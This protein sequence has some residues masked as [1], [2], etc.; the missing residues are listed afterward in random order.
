MK[1]ILFPCILSTLLIPTIATAQPVNVRVERWLAIQQIS[2]TVN[3]NRASATRAARVGDRLETVGDGVTTGTRSA[4]SLLFDTGVGVLNMLEN[5]NLRVRRMD[6]TADDG[7][8]T[9]LD[10]TRG[11]VRLKLRRFTSPN[12]EVEIRTPAGISGVRGTDF[13]V[14]VQPDGKT[15]VATLEGA[16]MTSAQ[17][18]EVSVPAGFQNFTIPGEPPSAAVPLRDDPSLKANFVKTI[19]RGIRKV[20][21]VGQVDPVNVVTV[22]GQPQSTDRN[23]QFTTAEVFARSFLRINVT[24]TTPLGKTQSYELALR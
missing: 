15:G 22:D 21:L 18:S 6:R 5:T 12:S 3:Y 8:I 19:D 17:G 2:G 4:A 13:G 20:Q 1:F 10:V 7:R 24:V 11:Q 23:G 9:H 16:V 14:V